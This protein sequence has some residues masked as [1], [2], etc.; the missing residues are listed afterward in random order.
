MYNDMQYNPI[1]GQGQ[2]HEPL[3][4][5]NPSISKSYL[6]RHLQWELAAVTTDS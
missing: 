2:G 6:F 1:Q 4:A 3:T 5:G